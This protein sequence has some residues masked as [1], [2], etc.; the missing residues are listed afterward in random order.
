M[1]LLFLL[2]EQRGRL[3]DRNQIAARLWRDVSFLD[4]ERSINT[5]VRKLRKALGDHPQRPQFLETVVGKGYRFILPSL[6][7]QEA[8]QY[9]VETGPRGGGEDVGDG[10]TDEIR[11][12]TFL[13]RNRRANAYL[14]L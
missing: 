1:E 8:G 6:P 11:L 12:G 5:A 4:T 14:D 13:G 3:V 7:V 10:N 2:L 9:S